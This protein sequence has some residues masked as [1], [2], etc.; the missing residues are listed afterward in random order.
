[1]DGDVV[2]DGPFRGVLPNLYSGERGEVVAAISSEAYLQ[3]WKETGH[4]LL[5]RKIEPGDNY[6]LMRC[7]FK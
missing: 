3:R 2:Y 7:K 1:M 4:D 6:L 5:S